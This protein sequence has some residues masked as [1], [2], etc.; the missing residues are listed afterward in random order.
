MKILPNSKTELEVQ[1]LNEQK[2]W[3]KLGQTWNGLPTWDLPY[4]GDPHNQDS[5]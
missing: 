1:E 5:I 4:Q 3:K 2:S